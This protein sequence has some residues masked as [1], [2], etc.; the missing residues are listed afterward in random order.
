M[1][2]LQPLDE[3]I[4]YAY[5]GLAVLLDLATASFPVTVVDSRYDSLP[6]DFQPIA[7]ADSAVASWYK[8]PSR[9]EGAAVG[10]SI[11][12]KRLEEEKVVFMLQ[13][14]E[15]ALRNYPSRL[16]AL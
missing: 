6:H 1:T 2:S 12:G 10:L 11:S 15:D 16:E 14:I 9:F 8:D 7:S 3:S 13:V 5:G 4:P